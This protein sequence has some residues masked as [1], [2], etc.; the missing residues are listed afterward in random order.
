MIVGSSKTRSQNWRKAR[1]RTKPTKPASHEDNFP[2]AWKPQASINPPTQKTRGL[3]NLG[4]PCDGQDRNTSSTHF[5][6]PTIQSP[7]LHGE[8]KRSPWRTEPPIAP[9][10]APPGPCPPNHPLKRYAAAI[11]T[12][13]GKICAELRDTRHSIKRSAEIRTLWA[14]LDVKVQAK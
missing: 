11:S 1:T 6:F 14:N 5:P 9:A 7:P 2:A 13:L 10:C 8:T 3:K 12:E 4:E